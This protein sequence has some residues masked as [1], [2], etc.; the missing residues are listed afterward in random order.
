LNVSWHLNLRRSAK[1]LFD[2]LS[3]AKT[4]RVFWRSLTPTESLGFDFKAFEH[5]GTGVVLGTAAILINIPGGYHCV[6]RPAGIVVPIDCITVC[7]RGV[8]RVLCVA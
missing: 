7:G 6:C 4:D 8:R 1:E 5:A 2:V 3:D